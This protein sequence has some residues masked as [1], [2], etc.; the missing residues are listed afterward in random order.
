MLTIVWEK[1]SIVMGDGTE[2]VLKRG[3]ELPSD[4]SDYHRQVYTMIGAVKDVQEAVRTVEAAAQA[5]AD[6]FEPAPDP[7]LPPEVPPPGLHQFPGDPA[8]SNEMPKPAVS[9]TKET[10]EN[11]AVQRDYMSREEAE[12]LT[13]A[14]LIAEVNRRESD[15]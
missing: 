7:V 2:K 6:S 8:A 11:Y 9:D 12:T 13:K 10:W 1:A 14:K 5:E 3:D 15:V 4:V